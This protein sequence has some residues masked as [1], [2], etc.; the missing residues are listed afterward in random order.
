MRPYSALGLVFGHEIL[1]HPDRNKVLPNNKP[2]RNRPKNVSNMT[3]ERL[4]ALIKEQVRERLNK[5]DGQGGSAYRQFFMSVLQNAGARDLSDIPEDKLDDFFNFIDK[6]WQAH[7]EGKSQAFS[8]SFRN[9]PSTRNTAKRRKGLKRQANRTT[10]RNMK[11]P[12]GVQSK[13]SERDVT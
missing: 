5:E 13:A 12:D 6:K 8:R 9:V 11:S 10:R 1:S 3:L 2:K 7:N 4:R